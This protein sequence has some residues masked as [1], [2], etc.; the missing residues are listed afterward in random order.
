MTR[1]DVDIAI[2]GSGFSGSILAM[3]ARRLGRTVALIERGHHP[4]FAIGESST[5]LASLLL[6]SI[7][8]TYDL[9]QLLPFTKYG[10]WKRAHADIGCGLKRGFSFF[11]HET[12]AP[13]VADSAHGNQLL[14]AASPNDD[15]GDVHW[16]RPDFDHFL[17]REA[18][19]LDVDYIDGVSLSSITPASAGSVLVGRR[20]SPVAHGRAVQGDA[21]EV[22]ISARLV[23][24]ASGPRGFLHSQLGLGE[25]TLPGLPGTQALYSHFTGVKP[26]CDVVPAAFTETTSSA[27]PYPPDAAAVHHVFDGGWIWVLHFDNGITS[28]GAAVTDSLARELRLSDGA[29]AWA[30]LMARVPSVGDQFGKAVPTRAFIHVPCLSF[31][32]D[33]VAGNGW[34][35]LPS[36]AG[37][38][39]PLLSTGFPLTLLG[40]ERVAAVIADAWDSPALADRLSA[41]AQRTT[42]ELETTARVVGALYDAFGDW[43]RFTALSHLYFAAAS[44]AESA[45]RLAPNSAI[46]AAFLLGDN[47]TFA[48]G[49]ARCLDLARAVNTGAKGARGALLEAIS[50]TVEP[51]NVAG[52]N[53]AARRNWYPCAADDLL[54]GAAKLNAGESEVLAMLERCGFTP[55]RAEV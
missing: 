22:L 18:I 23:V 49:L 28:A 32:S 39:D 38:V 12:G 44:F 1:H 2:I 7:A 10:A 52:L 17:V 42:S 55:R 36:A 5:P 6:E 43:E 26:F 50:A 40:V 3:I 25:R 14:V 13:F 15:I 8:R 20:E 46:G 45:R 24:D 37:I 48:V 9:P 35:M 11:R 16:Y 47:Q 30:R 51:V 34:V 27:L 29:E 21:D 19:A 54:A 4:R 53:S 41:Y 33:A 31:L